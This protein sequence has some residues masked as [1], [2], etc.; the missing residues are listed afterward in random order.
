[1]KNLKRLWKIRSWTEDRK[2]FF[3]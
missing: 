2:F 1:M 3:L